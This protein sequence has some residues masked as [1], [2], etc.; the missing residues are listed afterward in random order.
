MLLYEA[1]AEGNERFAVASSEEALRRLLRPNELLE[2][3]QTA[4]LTVRLGLSQAVFAPFRARFHTFSIGFYRLRPRLGG[5]KGSEIR[6]GYSDGLQEDY[7]GRDCMKQMICARRPSG[8]QQ[9]LNIA[10]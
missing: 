1:W 5:D 10:A 2:M 8:G 7:E 4:G 3:A 6:L 9:A